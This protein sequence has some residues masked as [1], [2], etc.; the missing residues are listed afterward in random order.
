MFPDEG[1]PY[2][3]QLFEGQ[4]LPPDVDP[5]EGQMA[6]VRVNRAW[7]P[8]ILGALTSLT[9]RSTWRTD[10]PELILQTQ[11]R[12]NDLLKLFVIPLE[13]PPFYDDDE[14]ADDEQLPEAPWYENVADWVITAFLA[15]TFTP[16]AAIVYKTTIPRLRLAFR[17]G[18]LGAIARVFLNDL[19]IWTGDTFAPT[20]GQLTAELDAEAFA[21]TNN[22]GEPPWTLKVV[23]T[24]VEA[25]VRGRLS[26]ETELKLEVE[27]GDIRPKVSGMQLRQNGCVIEVSFDGDT[28]TTLYDPTDCVD[29]LIDQGIQDAID[30]GRIGNTPNQPGPSDPPSPGACKTYHVILE[31]ASVWHL[32]SSVKNGDRITVSNAS[33]GWGENPTGRWYCPN[34]NPYGLGICAPGV[35]DHE[36]DDPIPTLP[37]MQ[38]IA[39]FGEQWFDPLAGSTTVSNASVPVDVFF[40]ANDLQLYDNVGALSFDVEVCSGSWQK[41]FDFKVNSTGW[42]A[43]L[44]GN[45][46]AT[47]GVGILVNYLTHTNPNYWAARGYYPF[48]LPAGSAVTKLDFYF[49]G[50]PLGTYTKQCLVQNS[51]GGGSL[52]INVSGARSSPLTSGA[53]NYNT[54]GAARI[55][56]LYHNE[57]ASGAAKVTKIIVTGTGTEPTW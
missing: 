29:G 27:L 37:H 38:L 31:G 54:A 55:F 49:E 3:K 5:D 4:L 50:S 48:T 35:F 17:T 13:E 56:L 44:G 20:V 16:G 12:V 22:L 39:R 57:A 11:Y 19:E 26:E 25:G 46:N 53:I 52:G 45:I 8:V 21:L 2:R 40:Q 24:G 18:D 10:D 28:W 14:T 34:G 42:I 7:I 6:L 41:V 33:G 15:T 51:S 36:D 32:P 23:H 43:D 1:V 9:H 47:V 30:D